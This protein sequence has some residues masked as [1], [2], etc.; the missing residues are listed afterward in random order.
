MAACVRIN[1]R[2]V[3]DIKEIQ[4]ESKPMLKPIFGYEKEKLLDLEQA[5]EPLKSLF[6]DQLLEQ[7]KNAKLNSIN[8][9]DGLTQDESASI[10]L[11][12]L[13]WNYGS[14]SL[15]I[16]LNRTLREDDREK[17][18][19]WFKYLKLILTAFFKLP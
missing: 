5:C 7:I 13:E 6:D 1:P 12:T 15:Y 8:P 9:K 17:L 18:R 16:V 2:L 14:P 11:Y 19:P 4:D 10:R 3:V